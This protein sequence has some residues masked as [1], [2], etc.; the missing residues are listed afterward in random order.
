MAA[1]TEEY[2][3]AGT[4]QDLKARGCAI[5]TGGGHTF[6]V[7]CQSG[8]FYAVDN[9]CPHMG[10]PLERGN[11]KDGIRTCHWHHARFDLS[12]GG[13]FDPFADDVRSIP[14]EVVDDEVWVRPAL[15]PRDET[16]HWTGRP[17]APH[18]AP[19]VQEQRE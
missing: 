13:T 4:V 17:P 6:A 1:I 8:Q 5:V 16:K 14:V 12:S 2:I 9:R 15:P 18:G 3:R 19:A 7:F 10:F 11:V